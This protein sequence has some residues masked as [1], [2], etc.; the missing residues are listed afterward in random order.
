MSIVILSSVVIA[1]LNCQVLAQASAAAGNIDYET[2]WFQPSLID[3]AGPVCGNVLNFARTLFHSGASLNGSSL[4]KP[5]DI[6]G[7]EVISVTDLDSEADP[8]A[9]SGSDAAGV[10]ARRRHYVM[11]GRRKIYVVQ[12]LVP[13]CG[14]KCDSYKY[15]ASPS[16]FARDYLGRL[17]SQEPPHATP[18][19]STPKLL[20]P[21]HLGELY[22]ATF[23]QS[24]LRLLRL[25]WDAS[26]STICRVRLRPENIRALDDPAIEAMLTVLDSYQAAVRGLVRDAGNCGATRAV[27]HADRTLTHAL[28]ELLYRPGPSVLAGP[29]HERMRVTQQDK[30]ISWSLTGL[31]EHAAL[32]VYELRRAETSAALAAFYTAHFGLEPVT[33][34]VWARRGLAAAGTGLRFGGYEPFQRPS[35]RELRQ[36]ILEHRPI[37]TLRA[38]DVPL[39]VING[40]NVD[41]HL[42]GESM[43]NIAVDYPAALAYLLGLGAN[44]NAANAFGKTPLMYAAQHNAI[45]AA[46][47]LLDAGADPDT[48]TTFPDNTCYYTLET[49]S[50]TALHY[51][52]RNAAPDL[53]R[54]L[55]E[56]GATIDI[57][58]QTRSCRPREYPVDWLRR[59][60]R[61][62]AEQ[63]NPQMT[64]AGYQEL[65]RRLS[66]P[67]HGARRSTR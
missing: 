36:A 16:P 20:R 28:H 29:D 35:E 65:E 24:E 9:A 67:Y 66:L 6:R 15:V 7:L 64:E 21:K 19:S 39:D 40:T 13:G 25:D 32:T 46:R 42:H 38:I 33:A 61:I 50:M 26:W 11:T 23:A 14:G 12:E 57:R 8:V 60:N 54:L 5:I 27:A 56:G 10:H 41:Y 62:D 55:L 47:L 48:T 34:G 3:G 18:A 59:F 44:P 17:T 43:L 63:R 52:V 22:V 45:E 37:E 1:Q 4:K 51:A 2:A 58:T 30:L 53:I 49:A 31:A